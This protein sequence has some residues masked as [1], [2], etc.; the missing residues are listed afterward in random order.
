MYTLRRPSARLF[1]EGLATL[2]NACGSENLTSLLPHLDDRALWPEPGLWASPLSP[3]PVPRAYVSRRF[4]PC[5]LGSCC[6]AG[7]PFW[8]RKKGT[9]AGGWLMWLL[10]KKK[11]K[12]GRCWCWVWKC[13]KFFFFL[14]SENADISTNYLVL[15]IVYKSLIFRYQHI[16]TSQITVLWKLDNII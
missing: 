10:K 3:A 14:S 7:Q 12:T 6:W 8:R 2:F 1:L 5:G 13:L 4:G 16:Q 15:G 11:T 9:L